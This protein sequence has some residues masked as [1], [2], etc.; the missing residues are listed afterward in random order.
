MAWPPCGDA[1]DTSAQTSAVYV[2]DVLEE[3]HPVLSGRVRIAGSGEL[4]RWVPT[5]RGL[6]VREGDR[7][8]VAR[9][10]GSDEPTVVGVLDG[11]RPRQAVPVDARTIELRPGEVLSIHSA[12]GRPLLELRPS[13]AG[14]VLC[15]ADP[16]LTLDVPG[17][18]RLLADRIELRARHGGVT[19]DARDDVALRGEV[20]HLN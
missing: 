19:V 5:L 6:S 16:D 20:I 11:L 18:L 9:A 3:R 12:D 2:A 8:L 17:A 7:V 14:P 1:H 10:A 13:D 15:L 4:P